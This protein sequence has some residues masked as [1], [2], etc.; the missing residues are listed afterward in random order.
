MHTV[1]ILTVLVQHH[2][3]LAY[4]LIFL[5]LI[6]E[7]EFFLISTGILAHLGALDFWFALIF[8][9]SGGLCKTFLGYYIGQTVSKKWPNMKFASYIERKV[10]GVAPKFKKK[11][12]WSIFISKFIMGANHL[13]ILFCGYTKIDYKKYL[14][15]EIFSTIIWAPLL[16]SLGYFFSYTALHISKEISRFLLI[17]LIFIIGY[18]FFDKIIGWFYELFEELHNNNGDIK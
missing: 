6:F 13:V 15:A 4:G 14:K 10:L 12:F 1:R 11:P 16:L 8:I 5:G 2:E 18:I 7:G 17:I 9:Y 3:A